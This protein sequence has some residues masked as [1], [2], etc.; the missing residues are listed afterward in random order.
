MNTNFKKETIKEAHREK[1]TQILYEK[2]G[3]EAVDALTNYVMSRIGNVIAYERRKWE[4]RMM[5]NRS[6]NEP[7]KTEGLQGR[8]NK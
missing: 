6:K 3:I 2:D 5:R 1:I 4:R 8:I 7:K